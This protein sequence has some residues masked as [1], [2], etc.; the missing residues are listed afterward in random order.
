MANNVTPTQH[1]YNDEYK[2]ITFDSK[3]NDFQV[4]IS[5]TFSNLL[6]AFG[7]NIV[8]K[9]FDI[10]TITHTGSAVSFSVGTG[11]AIIDGCLVNISSNSD[12]AY[13]DA[14]L[15]SENGR[16]IAYISYK[17]YQQTRVGL[18]DLT[19]QLSYVSSAGV[20]T[21]GWVDRKDLIVIDIFEFTVNDDGEIDTFTKSDDSYVTINGADYYKCGSSSDNANIAKLF[22]RCKDFLIH[23]DALLDGNMQEIN[24]NYEGFITSVLY[25][26][27]LGRFENDFEYNN[28][29]SISVMT[30]YFRDSLVLTTN[31]TYDFYNNLIS[32]TEV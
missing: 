19:I 14:N 28:N 6:K 32:W 2:N 8:S 24:Y 18:N 23:P 25:D 7:N 13:P 3:V 16:F 4:F 22:S 15:L 29:D 10:S 12:L 27:V 9:G 17:Y 30:S 21:P 1:H 5:K 11:Y 31:Y 20:V 26:T